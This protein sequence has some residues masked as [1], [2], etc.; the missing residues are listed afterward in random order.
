MLNKE[1]MLPSNWNWQKQR[2]HVYIISY[3]SNFFKLFFVLNIQNYSIAQA[4]GE[5]EIDM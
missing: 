1:N 2:W 3:T 4:M 5:A